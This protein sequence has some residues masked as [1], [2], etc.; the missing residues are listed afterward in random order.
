MSN[1][2]GFLL[3]VLCFTSIA[4]AEE[5]PYTVNRMADAYICVSGTG[6]DSGSG[7]A[8]L[9]DPTLCIQP[10]TLPQ[11]KLWCPTKNKNYGGI[12]SWDIPLH[13]VDTAACVLR[14][15]PLP[16]GEFIVVVKDYDVGRLANISY[17]FI[18]TGFCESKENYCLAG[19]AEIYF[20]NSKDNPP[21]SF[22]Q[23][24]NDV[25]ENPVTPAS[26]NL[27]SRRTK[28]ESRLR[29]SG[30]SEG[31]QHLISD[32][33]S[34]IRKLC[35]DWQL[36]D[37][38][39]LTVAVIKYAGDHTR[40]QKLRRTA[41]WMSNFRPLVNTHYFYKGA[42]MAISYGKAITLIGGQLNDA[43]KQL[44]MDKVDWLLDK[45]IPFGQRICYPSD[46]KKETAQWFRYGG[47]YK[48]RKIPSREELGLPVY[49]PLDVTRG[50]RA[51]SLLAVGCYYR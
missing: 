7:K 33:L 17:D 23:Q 6:W 51:P 9:P 13:C 1:Y 37:E 12:K 15:I 16:S 43:L 4:A 42:E 38:Y 24:A 44:G 48:G 31:E 39:D 18:G 3:L 2:S 40:A 49:W 36:L 35:S 29:E 25:C 14:D 50:T 8:Y 22:C 19:S 47:A 11:S 45:Y 27:T 30:L 32:E 34:F 26:I 10:N 28:L 5:P 41:C 20:A 21:D 46:Y